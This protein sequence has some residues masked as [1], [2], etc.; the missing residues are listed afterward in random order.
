MSNK[1]LDTRD[2]M[3]RRHDSIS[4]ALAAMAQQYQIV[5]VFFF[6]LI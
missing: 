2:V 3:R 4:V 1:M 6:H 5:F